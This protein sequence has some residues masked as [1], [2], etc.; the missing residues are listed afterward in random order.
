[1]QDR[2]AINSMLDDL[3]VKTGPREKILDLPSTKW[4]NYSGARE[5][6]N[7]ITPLWYLD[8]GPQ[9][10]SIFT[11]FKTND[12]L[13]IE[14]VKPIFRL[15]YAVDAGVGDIVHRLFVHYLSSGDLMTDPPDETLTETVTVTI[16]PADTDSVDFV[17]DKTKI[18]LGDRISLRYMRVGNDAGD[19]YTGDSYFAFGEFSYYNTGL[20]S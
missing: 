19:T 6:N 3:Y 12:D 15:H 4:W 13:D 9:T 7:G 11:S 18:K 5:A 8:S 1:M 17:L 10:D 2:D 20:R 16:P 14:K